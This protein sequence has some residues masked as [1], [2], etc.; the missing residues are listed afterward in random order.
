[1]LLALRRT[2]TNRHTDTTNKT[3]TNS[4][5]KRLIQIGSHAMPAMRTSRLAG[6]T[7]YT[8]GGRR[9]QARAQGTSPTGLFCGD[10][11]EVTYQLIEARSLFILNVCRSFVND[12]YI[13]LA[14]DTFK[15]YAGLSRCQVAFASPDSRNRDL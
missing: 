2:S 15:D 4:I 6:N 7:I 9:K 3:R 1:M 11:S 12:A 8:C 13:D 14:V 10:G 5:M